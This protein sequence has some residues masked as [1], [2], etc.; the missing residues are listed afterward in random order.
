MQRLL[1]VLL[2]LAGFLTLLHR[3][4]ADQLNLEGNIQ[5]R[6]LL[7]NLLGGE[8]GLLGGLLGKEG[9]L[10]GLLGKEGLLGN[11]LNTLLCLLEKLGLG[12][13]LEL[14]KGLSLDTLL[15]LN[16]IACVEDRVKELI[17][18]IQRNG[19]SLFTDEIVCLVKALGAPPVISL[20]QT[21]TLDKIFGLHNITCPARIPLFLQGSRLSQI[22][23]TLI[24]VL[25]LDLVLGIDANDLMKLDKR[26]TLEGIL[27][28]FRLLQQLQCSIKKI[29]LKVA[30]ASLDVVGVGSYQKLNDAVCRDN[31]RSKVASNYTVQFGIL[32]IL[33]RDLGVDEM[34]RIIENIGLTSALQIGRFFIQGGALQVPEFIDVICVTES[35][36]AEVVVPL[37]HGLDLDEVTGLR[38]VFCPNGT[39]RRVEER[40]DPDFVIELLRTCRYK[41]P[42]ECV[43]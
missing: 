5:E 11:L 18:L 22:L 30:I 33:L 32:P 38:S 19:W 42:E 35:L 28:V 10:G 41:T 34:I 14:L 9:L 29:S 37:L 25:G 6:A 4:D 17:D 1:A 20:L 2:V 31:I 24:N 3:T 43:T 12:V 15:G 40:I 23:L 36:G 26:I 8:G 39:A 16:E 13:V 21:E 7:G 27:D